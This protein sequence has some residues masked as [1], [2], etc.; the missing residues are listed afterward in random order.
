MVGIA[1]VTGFGVAAGA[2]FIAAETT[3]REAESRLSAV[4]RLKA[5]KLAS[6]LD[7]VTA[8]LVS[9]AQR[10]ETATAVSLLSSA[11]GELAFMEDATEVLQ[12]AYIANNP[13]PEGERSRYEISTE[14]GPY[15]KYHGMFHPRFVALAAAEPYEDIFL[16]DQRENLLYSLQKHGDFATN[17]A[18][19]KGNF[20]TTALG[21]A[22]QS[23]LAAP[24]GIAVTTDIALYA[25]TGNAAQFIATAVHK[26]GNVIGVM[27]ARIALT[28]LNAV[29]GTREGLSNTGETLVTGFDSLMRT[30]S[31]FTDVDDVLTT[32]IDADFIN[33]AAG[34]RE[35]RGMLSNY[36]GTNVFAVAVPYPRPEARWAVVALQTEAELMAAVGA[37][38]DTMV[39]IGVVLVVIAA[40]VGLVFSRAIVRPISK[41]TGVMRTL[42]AGDYEVDL[43]GAGRNRRD[44]V[45]AMARAVEVFRENG[46]RVNE[47]AEA[48][49]AR[50]VATQA[51]RA[52][53]ILELQRAFGQVVDAA[54]AGDFSRRVDAVF[55][56][57]ELNTLARSV[58]EL[59]ET[60]DRGVT[61]TGTVL[62]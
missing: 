21:A 19:N 15:D 49:A 39:W 53:M 16:L 2:Y 8:G 6:H 43:S 41:L 32:V 45:G 61:E 30:N 3:Q 27:A 25:P 11:Y 46:R 54:I 59:V 60:V 14:A 56:D 5:D 37:M 62:S 40:L 34:G 20:S 50:V 13:Y 18:E 55:P 12:N 47:M 31:D 24:P 33:A 1:L 44:E 10:T 58:N 42:A 29:M 4:A 9:F 7:S 35:G 52:A 48:E 28:S 23:A 57:D 36:R 51:E 26:D 38:R 17:F 22:F